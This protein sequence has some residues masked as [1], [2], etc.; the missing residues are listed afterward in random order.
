MNDHQCSNM[1]VET[2][3]VANEEEERPFEGDQGVNHCHIM[4]CGTVD[5]V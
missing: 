3:D 5:S 2:S 1:S 4:T